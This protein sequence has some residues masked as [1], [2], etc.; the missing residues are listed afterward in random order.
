MPK[1]TQK[2]AELMIQLYSQ[3]SDMK[4]FQSFIWAWNLEEMDYHEFAEKYPVGSDG[5]NHFM[6]V[7]TYYELVGTLLK[8]GTINEDIVLDF[9]DLIWNK[10]GKI[11]KGMQEAFDSPAL[12]ENYEWLAQRKSE[13][14]K[15]RRS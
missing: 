1:P 9:H 12:F 14:V 10:L 15:K 7:C 6:Q 4:S 11:V 8:Y 5:Y 2:D 3:I 13:W